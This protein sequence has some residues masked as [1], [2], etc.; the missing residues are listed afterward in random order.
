[1]DSYERLALAGQLDP[2]TFKLRFVGSFN[3]DAIPNADQVRRMESNGHLELVNQYV[4]REE[5]LRETAES[6]YLLVL[7]I[8]KSNSDLQVPCKIY[9]YLRTGRPVLAFT[10]ANSPLER[11]I[12]NSGVAHEILH[13]R[14]SSPEQVDAALLRLI[15]TAPAPRTALPWY[16]DT[17]E[18]RSLS[19]ILADEL[20][21][22]LSTESG[23]GPKR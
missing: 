23:E 21:Q 7:D 15:N 6:D 22:L 9:D 14:I 18:A 13:N 2:A 8:N 19:R 5:A 4:S 16:A 3:W 12:G 10:P 17:H 1:L 11:I 20:D